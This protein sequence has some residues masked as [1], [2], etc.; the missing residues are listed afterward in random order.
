[1]TKFTLADQVQT[2]IQN[3]QDA[4]EEAQQVMRTSLSRRFTEASQLYLECKFTESHAKFLLERLQE[5]D[6]EFAIRA[7]AAKAERAIE[8][9]LTEPTTNTAAHIKAA[10][11]MYKV[12]AR[13]GYGYLYTGASQAIA[14]AATE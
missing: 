12:I 1:M 2:C 3:A 14:Y 11:A 4:A 10:A 5:G 7:E 13:A 9:H 8:L 6:T